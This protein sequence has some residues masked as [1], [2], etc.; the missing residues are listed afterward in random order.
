MPLQMALAAAVRAH[1]LQMQLQT[2]WPSQEDAQRDS[3]PL[4]ALYRSHIAAALDRHAPGR[5]FGCC[6]ACALAAGAAADQLAQ[7]GGPV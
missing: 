4:V 6:C 5:D 2:S 7:P 3:S 1:S